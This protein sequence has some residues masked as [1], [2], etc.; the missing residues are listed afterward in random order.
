[1]LFKW[2][3]GV[4]ACVFIMA[5]VLLPKCRH[6]LKVISLFDTLCFQHWRRHI[7]YRVTYHN[8]IKRDQQ[9]IVA[10]YPHGVCSA[11]LF[12]MD[13]FGVDTLCDATSSNQVPTEEVLTSCLRQLI[14][15][16]ASFSSMSSAPQVFPLGGQMHAS[17]WSYLHT[18][19]INL[20]SADVLLLVPIW[21]HYMS[22]C[23]L[24]FCTVC[25]PLLSVWLVY[26]WRCGV[27]MQGHVSVT[28]RPMVG[29]RVRLAS[30]IRVTRN[31]R[32]GHASNQGSD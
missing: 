31:C 18:T 7:S 26:E 30:F 8:E 19:K 21:R 27:F 14:M 25:N 5:S 4:Y 2:K 24:S 28:A 23:T 22:A 9:Y 1:M 11:C 29:G 17:I 16:S 10:E 13:L 3:P 20:L 12:G 32:W 15:P 6:N